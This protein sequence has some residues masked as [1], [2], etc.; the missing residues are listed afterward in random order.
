MRTAEDDG[1]AE[2]NESQFYYFRLED[3]VPQDHLLRLIYQH[4]DLSFVR[5]RLQPFHSSTGAA[6]GHET[7]SETQL[8]SWR[9][10][11]NRSSACGSL[12]ADLSSVF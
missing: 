4:V 10:A 1:P 2:R 12:P 6:L 3:Q 9:F 11:P 5:E 8:P 7:A